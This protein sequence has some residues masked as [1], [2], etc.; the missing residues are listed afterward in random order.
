MTEN[1]THINQSDNYKKNFGIAYRSSTIFYF[2]KS[3]KF[4]TLI[5][6]MDYWTVKKSMKVMVIASLRDLRGNLVLREKLSFD[7]GHVI[8]YS[9]NIEGEEFEGS[10][11][12]EA[13]CNDNLGIPFAAMLVVYEAENSISWVHGY[14]RT[15]TTHEIEE[16]RIIEKGEEAGLVCRDNNEIRSFVIGHNGISKQEKQLVQLWVSNIDGET[17][18]TEFELQELK[19]FETFKIYPRDH[20]NNL[21][22]F[23]KNQPG[24][25][26]I[27]YKLSGG[28]TRLVV[29]NETIKGDE[30]QVLHSNF[31][32]SRHYPGY[33]GDDIG[34]Y[35]FPFTK[36]HEKQ[37]T[38]MDPFCSEG[39]YEIITN[40]KKY[41]FSS[42]KRIDIDM[43][44]E[45]LQIKRTNGE[46][47]A[48]IN[49]VLSAFLKGAKCKL[50]MES[51]RGFYHSKR[52]PKYRM[53]MAASI[54]KKY[55]SKV[56][57]H[58]LTDLYGPVGDSKLEVI[59]Y[60]EG[61]FK[62]KTKVLEQN[63]LKRFEEGVY[64]D[65][66]FPEEANKKDVEMC[67]LFMKASSYGGHQ[68][69]TT[70]ESKNGSASVE[71]NY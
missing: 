62:T 61:T 2:K 63:D 59:L 23:L 13:I 25:C 65:D 26:A 31:N 5:N 38:H 30:F 44:T 3:K 9:P 17:L 58:S 68:A 51:A 64:V 49:I 41:D 19:P 35:S 37:T 6:F 15:Y 21:T 53:W 24:N 66:L 1:K 39:K 40:N 54:G 52:P 69:Y 28:F 50:P 16:G 43:E 12:M 46:L 22:D 45:V 11:E 42:S 7:K 70:I 60:R 33:V 8:N 47:P 18:K 55:R 29:G 34:Y 67:Q 57:I 14:T 32:Y 27:A 10:L 71:H 48:R 56:I 4:S 36:Q 20:I